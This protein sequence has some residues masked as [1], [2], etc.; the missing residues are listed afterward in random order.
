MQTEITGLWEDLVSRPEFCGHHVRITIVDESSGG[1]QS[2]PW[3]ASLH[4][5]AKNGVRITR[6]AD[7]SRQGIYE[8]R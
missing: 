7:D 4:E 3:L 2:D 8:D 5:M 1:G 6:P